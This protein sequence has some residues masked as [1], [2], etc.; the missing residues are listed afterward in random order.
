MLRQAVLLQV[1]LLIIEVPL[2]FAEVLLRATVRPE[3]LPLRLRLPEAV[4]VGV[5]PTVEAVLREV[6]AGDADREKSVKH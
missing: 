3:L 4:S 6:A 1:L 5:H 2:Q